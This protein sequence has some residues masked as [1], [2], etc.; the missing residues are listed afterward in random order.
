MSM[1]LFYNRKSKIFLRKNIWGVII[2]RELRKALV[3]G[4][5][6]IWVVKDKVS[7]F[8]IGGERFFRG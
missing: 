4:E 7:F 1:Y 5:Y 8:G 2:F 3:K 6:L